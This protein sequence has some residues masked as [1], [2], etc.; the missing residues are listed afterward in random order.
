MARHSVSSTLRVTGSV[1][2]HKVVILVDGGSKHN[3]IQ[4]H[5]ARFLHLATQPTKQLH[6]MVG[7][8]TELCCNQVCKAISIII[9][10]HQ[11]V[12]DLY[13]MALGGAN[14]VFGVEWLKTL[15]PITT[16]YS[17]LTMSLSWKNEPV[18]LSG[19]KGP[20]PVEATHAQIRR[21][22]QTD[23][24]AA[25]FHLQ[26]H[27]SPSLSLYLDIPLPMVLRKLLDTYQPILSQPY[28][29]HDY[30]T[31]RF[32]F[33]PIINLSMLS[34]IAIHTFKNTK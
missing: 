33:Y 15:G 24:V 18:V 20:S 14:I 19:Q 23:W 12:V 3:F 31:T 17:A 8:D 28:P 11:F 27:E 22:L 10:G 25:F 29:Q 4:D 34:R 2:G 32:I 5:I 30:M 1:Q 26:L 6:V 9:Q 16:D 13:V 7:N 21:L